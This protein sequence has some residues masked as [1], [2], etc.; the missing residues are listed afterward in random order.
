MATID[1]Q[2]IEL[3]AVFD[4]LV[5]EEASVLGE[6]IPET[7]SIAISDTTDRIEQLP[8]VS[9]AAMDVKARVIDYWT[10]NGLDRVV[11]IAA[12]LVR[13]FRKAWAEGRFV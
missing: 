6:E 3:G 2:L 11:P 10:D 7:L 13:D 9:A 5:R 8:A 1:A 12:S 4:R